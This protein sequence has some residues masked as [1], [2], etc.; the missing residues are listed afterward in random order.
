MTVTQPARP[1]RRRVPRNTLNPDRIL[2]AAL[3]L[4]DRDGAEAFTMRALAQELGVGTMAV[5]SHFRGK[6]E[7]SD[8]VARRLLGEIE[9]PERPGETD[10]ENAKGQGKTPA[11][12]Y[13]QILEVCRSLFRLFTE[14]PSALQLLTNR[15]LRGDEAIAVL[16]RVLGLLRDAGLDRSAALTAHVSIMQYTVGAALWTVRSERR[17]ECDDEMR[18]QVRARLA[19]LPP[20]SYPWLADLG[21]ELAAVDL[22]GAEQYE[23]GLTALLTGLLGR[24]A[25]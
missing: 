21:P 18:D 8:A 22:D 1:P 7:I 20:G 25:P 5:Y 10:G 9:L 15:P 13:G 4:L 16:D 19:D 12:P 11:D 24:A 3:S 23:T 6:D 14:H 17:Q 2:D